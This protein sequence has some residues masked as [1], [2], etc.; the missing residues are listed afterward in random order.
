MDTESSRRFIEVGVQGVI[1]RED[2]V[3]LGFRLNTY[4]VGTWGLPGGRL[5]WQE[6]LEKCIAREV[7]EETSLLV[8]HSHPFGVANTVD[9]SIGTHHVQIGMLIDE[10][11][12]EP[13]VMEPQKC[14][15]WRFFS[16]IELPDRIFSSSRPLLEQLVR[17]MTAQ[18]KLWL[19]STC[20]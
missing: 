10:Y 1:L 11:T 12:G 19:R 2:T 18:G 7:K 5:E 6:S 3:L 15:E 4:G 8:T 13:R 14:R 20:L 9:F 17:T 16:L